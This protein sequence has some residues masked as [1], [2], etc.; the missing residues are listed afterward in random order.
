MFGIELS[1]T[2]YD[3]AA[4]YLF[5]IVRNHPF[6][7]ENKRTGAGSAYLFLRI[8]KARI[9][10]ESSFENEAF[11]NFVIKIATSKKNKK[12]SCVFLNTWRR[13]QLTLPIQIP[14]FFERN[15]PI[16]SDDEMVFKPDAHDAA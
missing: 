9:L 16:S 11:E 14:C 4:A 6:N 2:I 10:F 15:K 13:M 8:N 7:D 3:K 1:P 12:R 5:N